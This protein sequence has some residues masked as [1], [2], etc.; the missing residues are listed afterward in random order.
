VVLTWTLPAGAVSDGAGIIIQESP[1]LSGGG[2]VALSRR[3]TGLPRSYIA[4]PAPADQQ[5]CFTVGVVVER[6]S[7]RFQLIQ[8]GSACA[9]PR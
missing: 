1:A 3:G 7:G 4:A 5:V 2:T 6:T 8:A 9:I